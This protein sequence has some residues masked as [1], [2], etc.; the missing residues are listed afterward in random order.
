MRELRAK[1]PVSDRFAA[2]CCTALES[3][4]SEFEGAE[5]DR[6]VAVVETSMDRQARVQEMSRESHRALDGITVGLTRQAE[7]LRRLADARQRL[8][9]RARALAAVAPAR[10]RLLH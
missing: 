4:L 6:L 5:R 7:T 1:H 3:I 10:S 2:E 8:Q 9:Q